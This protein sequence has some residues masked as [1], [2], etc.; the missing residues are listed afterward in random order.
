VSAAAVPFKGTAAEKAKIKSE[1]RQVIL[2]YAYRGSEKKPRSMKRNI[3]L[4]PIGNSSGRCDEPRPC[5]FHH[6]VRAIW[7]ERPNLKPVTQG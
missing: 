5:H 3:P 1:V 6:W 2:F 7:Q 4:L